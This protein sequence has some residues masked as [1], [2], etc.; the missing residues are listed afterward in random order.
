MRTVIRFSRQKVYGGLTESSLWI[1]HEEASHIDKYVGLTGA[2]LY[3]YL[4]YAGCL[5][6]TPSVPRQRRVRGRQT[7]LRGEVLNPRT[8]PLSMAIKLQKHVREPSVALRQGCSHRLLTL[9]RLTAIKDEQEHRD[10]Y[11]MT[12][13]MC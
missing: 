6:L 3:G 8:H 2:R 12:S 13:Y 5:K 1:D 10:Q 9:G 4:L 7:S 11:G